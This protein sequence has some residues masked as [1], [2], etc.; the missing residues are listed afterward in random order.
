MPWKITNTVLDP[1]RALMQ[2][3]A[4]RMSTEP[5]VCGRVLRVRDSMTITDAQYEANKTSIEAMCAQGVISAEQVGGA[6]K[7]KA[8]APA[9]PPPAPEPEPTPEPE[10]APEPEPDTED[11]AGEEEDD[12]NSSTPKRRRRK[13]GK[14]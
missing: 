13:K 5:M 12:P 10:A 8:E 11:D 1:S 6:A 3:Q 2:R 9:P 7:A 14:E 4:A